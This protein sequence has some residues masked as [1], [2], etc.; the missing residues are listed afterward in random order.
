[1]RTTSLGVFFAPRPI[2]KPNFRI[3]G[4]DATS[5]VQPPSSTKPSPCQHGNCL[6]GQCDGW[7]RPTK[8][9]HCRDSPYRSGL[10]PCPT[11]DYHAVLPSPWERFKV[12]VPQ[13]GAPGLLSFIQLATIVRFTYRVYGFSLGKQ[14]G[15]WLR[16]DDTIGQYCFSY[17]TWGFSPGRVAIKES[18]CNIVQ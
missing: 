11:Q 5:T 8:L 1:M 17:R 15:I 16:R 6:V 18:L 12:H 4:A 13:Q 2:K 9:T 7:Q 3:S 14:G 10:S